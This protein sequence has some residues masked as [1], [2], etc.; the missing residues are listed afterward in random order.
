MAFPQTPLDVRT[1]LQI[2][3]TWTDVTADTYLRDLIT[4]TGGQAAISRPGF[5]EYVA[6]LLARGVAVYL[7]SPAARYHTG[8]AIVIDGGYT[9]F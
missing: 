3:G 4:I 9:I 6:E 7:S 5:V 2:G 8:D 1:D